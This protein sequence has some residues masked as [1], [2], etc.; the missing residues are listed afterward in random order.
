MKLHETFKYWI[1]TLLSAAF[2]FLTE[3]GAFYII[4][5]VLLIAN[6]L[7][8]VWGEFTEAEIKKEL[9]VFYS[10]K[11]VAIIKRISAVLLLS[12]VYWSVWFIDRK[13]PSWLFFIA[14]GI[15]TGALTGCFVVTLAHDLLHGH[16]K[17]DQFLS[18][19]LLISA[20]I[21]HMAADHVFGHHRNIGLAKDANT[22]KF[23]QDFYSYFFILV[24]DRIKES[25]FTQFNLPGYMRKKVFRLNIKMLL[26]LIVVW[27][28]IFFFA[29][30]PFTALGFFIFQGCVSYFLYELINY[31][32][33]YG[34]SRQHESNKITQ[35]L[36]WNCYYKYTNYILHLLPLHSLHHLPHNNRTIKEESLK[37]APRMPYVYFVMVFMALVPPLWFYKM[38][39]L[40][41]QYNARSYAN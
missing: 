36:S 12:M 1:P 20:G 9:R 10:D 13:N 30:N 16:K 34:L 33:H 26:F 39:K 40:V 21:P 41:L 18:A 2:I 27:L 22:S 5:P 6:T 37:D 38:N 35:S 11:T 14:F 31:I 15:C 17:I 24:V 3:A 19:M 32:Q 29:T 23:N 4:L 25:Y 8:I 7:N 28:V